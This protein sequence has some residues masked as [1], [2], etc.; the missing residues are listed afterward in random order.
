[1]RFLTYAASAAALTL[2][3]AALAPT[4]A[5][6]CA[7]GCGIFDIGGGALMPPD[8]PTG[9]SA[10]FRYSYMDQ[11]RNREGGHAAAAADNPDKSIETH[12]Y[13]FG[14]QYMINHKWTIMAEVPIYDRTFVSTDD[15]GVAGPE[16]SVYRARETGLGD[17]Q[18]T[19]VYTG[20]AKDMSTG[21]SLGVKL[22]TGDDKGP[23]GPLGGAEFDRD[24][25]PGTGSTDLMFGAYHIGRFDA[26]GRF[27]WFAQ[28]RY[29]V[30]VTTRGGY[31]PGDEFNTAVGVGY[32]LGR[33]GPFPKVAPVLQL[34]NSHRQRDSGDASD[35]LN[36][37]YERLLIG[38]GLELRAGKVRLFIDVALPLYEHVNS[39]PPGSGKAGQLTAPALVNVQATYSF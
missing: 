32:D 28:A 16:G 5:R 23:T 11:T 34:I 25:L 31:R 12:F 6:A 35:T 1:M 18:L 9:F 15:G 7:C 26:E 22:P 3:L 2:G 24:T 17:A 36:S 38:P 14:G 10:W 29:Q 39:A 8:S 4:A 20:L 33:I 13:T 21:L 37:G 27:S 19:A 30:A